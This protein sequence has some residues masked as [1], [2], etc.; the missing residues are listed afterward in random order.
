M[1]PRRSGI[2]MLSR[3]AANQG[4]EATRLSHNIMEPPDSNEST[5]E[6]PFARKARSY[7]FWPL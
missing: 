7:G 1:H 6:A 4:L 2:I 5:A 3:M